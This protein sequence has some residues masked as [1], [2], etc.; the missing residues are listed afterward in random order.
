MRSCTQRKDATPEHVV[1]DIYHWSPHKDSLSLS[2][3]TA[4]SCYLSSGQAPATRVKK[5][6]IP[7][8]IEK[9]GRGHI[10]IVPMPRG[11]T[12]T[13]VILSCV[14]HQ[15]SLQVPCNCSSSALRWFDQFLFGC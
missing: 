15:N 7:Y 8:D 9:G 3:D 11:S 13:Q 1:K 4:L 5:Q 12:S 2:I 6:T 14:R 10:E